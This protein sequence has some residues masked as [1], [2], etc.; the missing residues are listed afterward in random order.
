LFTFINVMFPPS[1]CYNPVLVWGNDVCCGYLKA[2]CHG[3]YLVK[4]GM[5]LQRNGSNSS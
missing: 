1:S 5:N 3:G 4:G 2:R